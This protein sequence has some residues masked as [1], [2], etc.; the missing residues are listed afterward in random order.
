MKFNNT[1][2]EAGI[3]PSSLYDNITLLRKKHKT[4]KTLTLVFALLLVTFPIALFFAFRAKKIRTELE[5]LAARFGCQ[6]LD[7]LEGRLR[8]Y[9]ASAETASRAKGQKENAEKLLEAGL[10]RHV[11]Q[12][13]KRFPI[14]STKPAAACRIPI[15]RH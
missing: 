3:N 12:S 11:P 9:A 10:V 7:E 2:D 14:C 15:P 8:A 13:R 5:K 1:I 4:A 6:T